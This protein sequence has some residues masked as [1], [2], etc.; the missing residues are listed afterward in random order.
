MPPRVLLIAETCNPEWVSVPLVGWLQY[1]ALAEV[2]DVHLV[3]QVRNIPAIQRAGLRL[4]KDFTAIDNEAIAAASTWLHFPRDKAF[5]LWAA[6]QA[7]SYPYFEHLLYKQFAPALRA[8][9]YDVVHRLTPLSPVSSSPLAT[10]C[11]QIGVPFVVG[12]FN[13]GVPWPKCFDAARRREAEW[14]SYIRSA[15]RLVPTIRTMYRDASA[16][17]VASRHT[18]LQVPYSARSRTFYLPE[19]GVDPQRFSVRRSHCA[20]RPLR[21]IFV[22]RL[23][24]YKGPDMLIEAAEP[25]LRSG[26]VKLE[27][28]GD[29]PLRTDLEKLITRLGLQ[30]HVKMLGW[31]QHQEVQNRLAQSD[32]FAFPSI[33]EF[34]GGAILEAMAIGVVPLVVDYAGPAELVTEQTGYRISLGTRAQIIASFRQQLIRLCENPTE[35]DTKSAACYRRAHE[36]FTWHKK[37]LRIREIYE[38]TMHQRPK[39]FFPMPM[40]DLAE[41]SLSPKFAIP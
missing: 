13:G 9:K 36:Q 4:G 20:S 34:G 35:I 30:D 39:P 2:A 31:V 5:T 11:K 8:G 28:A 37:A 12:P 7:L 33:R 26:L 29:G 3:T 15:F 27:I 21:L 14:L 41:P 22:G 23:V 32:L 25:L 19:N 38:W 17:L 24:P 18:G 6:L 16:I 40:P 10:W 1:K